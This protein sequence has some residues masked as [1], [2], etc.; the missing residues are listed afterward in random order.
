[1]LKILLHAESRADPGRGPVPSGDGGDRPAGSQQHRVRPPTRGGGRGS[2]PGDGVGPG[3][4]LSRLVRL[5]ALS[6]W[7]TPANWCARRPSAQ[8]PRVRV[9]SPRRQ[10]VEPSAVRKGELKALDLGLALLNQSGPAGSELTTSGEIMAPD[11][12]APSSGKP[13]TP[14][15]P[16]RHLR[17]RLYLYTPRGPGPSPGTALAAEDGGA[18]RGAVPADDLPP[19]RRSR[20]SGPPRADGGQEPDDR[21]STPGEVAAALE[22]FCRAQTCRPGR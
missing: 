16:S 11:Y 6:P 9:G 22:P 14:W 20:I 4:N 12:T 18:P 2:L 13:V 1:V 17:S 5:A 8:R 19:A 15:T 10:A 7:P 3:I 21:P